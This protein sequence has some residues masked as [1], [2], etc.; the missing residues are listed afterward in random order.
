MRTIY[1]YIDDN[2]NFFFNLLFNL[3]F[4]ILIKPEKYVLCIYIFRIFNVVLNRN[5]LKYII[6]NRH[7]RHCRH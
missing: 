7:I 3:F 5:Q 4:C 6:F 1:I 2:K